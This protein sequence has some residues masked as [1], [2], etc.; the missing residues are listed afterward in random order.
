MND[1]FKHRN[2]LKRF[3]ALSVL[4]LIFLMR[5]PLALARG[6]KGNGGAKFTA[7]ETSVSTY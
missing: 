4:L 1:F 3:T 7:T 2:P 6:P 5:I